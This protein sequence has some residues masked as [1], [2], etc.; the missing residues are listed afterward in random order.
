MTV[1][2]FGCPRSGTSILGELFEHVP[3]YQF[4]FEPSMYS[5]KRLDHGTWQ[6]ALKNPLGPEPWTP[7]LQ[8]DLDDLIASVSSP[9]SLFIHRHPLDVI[10]SMQSAMSR[11]VDHGPVPPHAAAEPD[12]LLRAAHI[13]DWINFQGLTNIAARL[14]THMI[15]YERLITDP[16][17]EIVKVLDRVGSPV[18]ATVNNY[19]SLIT[20]DTGGYEAKHQDRW[21]TDNHTH[22]I[23]RWHQE[24]TPS[25]AA[26]CWDVVANT[27]QQLGY[28]R[29]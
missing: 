14:E 5:V 22:R 17:N 9:T 2:L 29:D 19:T 26:A 10:C 13:W 15:R 18:P 20:D 4:Y 1:L 3:G 16:Y 24:I 27:A 8:C 28:Q 25:A 21:V 12:P 23:N 6:W 11:G 7:G